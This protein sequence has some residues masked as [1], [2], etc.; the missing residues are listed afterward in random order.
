[1]KQAVN[2]FKTHLPDSSPVNLVTDKDG[3]GRVYVSTYPTM[4]G[5]IDETERRHP[6]VRRGPLRSGD[7]R[8]GPP[9]G[10][11]EV[12]RHLRLLRL[13]AGRPDRH[14]RD[15]SGPNTYDLFDLEKG[16]PTDAY[17]LDDAVN[18]GYLVP[19][20]AVSVPL[21]FLREGIRYDDLSEDERTEWDALEWD[22]DVR[23]RP[24]RGSRAVNKWLFNTD[25]VDK[26]LEHLMTDGQK[27]AGGDRLGKTIIF[28]KNQRHAEFITSG[29]TSTTPA[30]P[31]SSP[32]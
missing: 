18:D 26:V 27:V 32:G 2:A 30:W 21:K 31:A 25:T 8:R 13:A 1:V 28:A 17:D 4:M 23:A 9:V 10:V 22:D 19:S 14:P 16:V 3:E 11:P 15:E 24:T 12:P 6:A 5:L 20:K 7:H 29:S